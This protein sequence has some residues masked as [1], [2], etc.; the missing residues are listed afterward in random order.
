[1]ES[2]LLNDVQ[3]LHKAFEIHVKK[4]PENRA[5]LLLA[6]DKEKDGV[7]Q[8]VS[9][10]ADGLQVSQMLYR[11]LT[12]KENKLILKVLCKAIIRQDRTVKPI[13]LMAFIVSLVWMVMLVGILVFNPEEWRYV[14]YPMLFDLWGLVVTGY[15]LFRVLN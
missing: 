13:T 11:F 7:H 1:M 14:V 4:D 6:M 3:A 2:E 8:S 10:C 12:Q 15:Y 9:R 5:V